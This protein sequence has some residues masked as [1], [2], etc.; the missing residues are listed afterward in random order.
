MSTKGG[1]VVKHDHAN[2]RHK[3]PLFTEI[4]LG[5]VEPESS[6]TGPSDRVYHRVSRNVLRSRSQKLRS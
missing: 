4:D 5:F 1:E 6:H 3:Y 2:A